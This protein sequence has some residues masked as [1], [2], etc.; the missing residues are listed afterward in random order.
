MTLIRRVANSPNALFWLTTLAM[1]FGWSLVTACLSGNLPYDHIEMLIWGKSWQLSYWKHPPLPAWA[2]EAVS[3]A[4]NRAI[5]PQ[6]FLGPATT[7]TAAWVVWRASRDVAGPWRALIAALSLQGCIYYNYECDLFN[8]NTIQLP[9]VAG[10][11]WAGWR[12]VRGSR[13]TGNTSLAWICFGACSAVAIYGKHTAGFAPVGVLAFTLINKDSR[14]LWRTRGPYLGL[15]TGTIVM[16]PHL[17]GLWQVDFLPFHSAFLYDTAPAPWWGRITYPLEF[18]GVQIAMMF[19]VWIMMFLLFAVPGTPTIEHESP[20]I[21]T[22]KA[23]LYFLW[24][25]AF[26]VALAALLSCVLNLYMHRFWAMGWLPYTGLV[27][28]LFVRRPIGFSGLR[29]MWIAWC[30][31][32]FG[33]LG[34]VA[35]RLIARPHITGNVAAVCFNGDQFAAQVGARWSKATGGAPLTIVIG[36]HWIAGNVAVYHSDHPDVIIDAIPLRAP[37]VDLKRIET[38]GA[39]LVWEEPM[40]PLWLDNFGSHTP[41]ERFEITPRTT[42]DVP[43]K[44]LSMS[45]ILPAGK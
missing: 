43:K 37:W 1:Y 29:T 28:L 5:W 7:A 20:A 30:V 15:L 21:E 11:I 34:F 35:V 6:F 12:A 44:A 31:L 32:A 38:E 41:I 9:L 19:G 8:H 17:I 4:T 25:T 26:P 2:T 40:P 22:R 33:I 23:A 42:A 27:V 10:L 18:V 16:V 36:T 3:L 24:C 13:E 45:I 39:V 14:W